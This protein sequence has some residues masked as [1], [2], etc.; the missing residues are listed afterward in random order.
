MGLWWCAFG[1]LPNWSENKA[2]GDSEKKGASEHLEDVV[3]EILAFN[4]CLLEN[5]NRII[6]IWFSDIAVEMKLL[7]NGVQRKWCITKRKNIKKPEHIYKRGSNHVTH[8]PQTGN[9]PRTSQFK[10]SVWTERDTHSVRVKLNV[11]SCNQTANSF[12]RRFSGFTE[13]RHRQTQLKPLTYIFSQRR[14][15][16]DSGFPSHVFLPCCSMKCRVV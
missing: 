10:P 4:K 15:E 7:W 9:H 11:V 1:M 12:I 13:L 16:G 3:N 2:G 14:T 6:L 8:W 5:R